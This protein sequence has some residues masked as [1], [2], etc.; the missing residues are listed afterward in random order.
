MFCCLVN[1]LLD[2]SKFVLY[3]QVTKYGN[4]LQQ[5]HTGP[6]GPVEA[7]I[8]GNQL[9]SSHHTI[10]SRENNIVVWYNLSSNYV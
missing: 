3:E 8:V 7:N 6:T 1:M 5:I 2:Q 10:T 9:E 4:L